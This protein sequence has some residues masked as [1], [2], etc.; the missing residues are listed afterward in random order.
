MHS[1]APYNA[2]VPGLQDMHPVAPITAFGIVPKGHISQLIIPVEPTYI[3][4]VPRGH[5]LQLVCALNALNLPALQSLHSLVALSKYS[6]TFHTLQP[7]LPT[8]PTINDHGSVVAMKLVGSGC[9][10]TR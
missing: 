9:E 8:P 4:A 1:S 3:F 2:R 7:P 10:A 5:G 6:P